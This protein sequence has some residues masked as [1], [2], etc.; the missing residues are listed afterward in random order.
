MRIFLA[1]RGRKSGSSSVFGLEWDTQHS[2]KL[3]FGDRY[4]I[5]F[6]EV[7]TLLTTLPPSI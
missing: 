3:P 7:L 6:Y 1:Q 4:S 2:T 5:P